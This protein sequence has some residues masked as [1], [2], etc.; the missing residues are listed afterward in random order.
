MGGRSREDIAERIL[1]K[2]MRARDAD[3]LVKS[4]EVFANWT[5][6]RGDTKTVFEQI[7]A[8]LS[9][10]DTVGRELLNNWR[11]LV[12]LIVASGIPEDRIVLQPNLARNWEYYTGIVFGIE[13]G[14]KFVAAGGRYDDLAQLITDAPERIPAVGFTYYIDTL[15]SALSLPEEDT[16]NPIYVI[17]TAE[18]LEFAFDLANRL[19][20][21]GI[22]TIVSQPPDETYKTI[23]IQKDGSLKIENAEY[24]DDNLDSLITEL[25]DKRN[26]D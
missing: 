1:H 9:D 7:E 14:D 11:E 2:R 22:P 23:H 24:T 19:R 8:M 18:Q 12:R 3:E 10:N 16:A 4:L 13:V 5:A 15:H 6:L 20:K 21:E 26:N 25:R 17:S